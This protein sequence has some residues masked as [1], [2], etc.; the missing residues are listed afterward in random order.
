MII[1][2]SH[3]NARLQRKST[4]PTVYGEGE[5]DLTDV[6]TTLLSCLQSYEGMHGTVNYSDAISLRARL[7]C[8]EDAI[9]RELAKEERREKDET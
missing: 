9:E 3:F 2:L 8:I 5:V 7:Y 4:A 1:S 6:L